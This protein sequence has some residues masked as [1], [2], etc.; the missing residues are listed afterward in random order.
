MDIE[1]QC[2]YLAHNNSIYACVSEI[3][4]AARVICKQICE[5]ILKCISI[6]MVLYIKEKCGTES[7]LARRRRGDQNF[8]A[9]FL[10]QII[11]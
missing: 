7:R 8:F 3:Y 4:I 10:K 5:G 9:L 6:E 11:N 2:I 1:H